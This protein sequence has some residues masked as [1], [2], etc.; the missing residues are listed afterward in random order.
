MNTPRAA[1]PVN[2]S[3][4]GCHTI[5]FLSLVPTFYWFA[6]LSQFSLLFLLIY[7][8]RHFQVTSHVAVMKHMKYHVLTAWGA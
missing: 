3:R 4:E 2:C 8:H 7:M 5:W 1:E 6:T